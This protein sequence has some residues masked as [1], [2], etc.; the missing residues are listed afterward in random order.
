MSNLALVK[1]APFG[2]V[3]CDFWQNEQHD[4]FMTIN[5][6]AQALG[7]ASKSGVEKIVQRNEYL[8]DIEFSATDILSAPDGKR[9]ETRIFTEDGIYEVSMLAKTPVAKDF[10]QWVRKILKSL[11]KGDY[12]LTPTVTPKLTVT[13]TDDDRKLEIEARLRNSKTR[14]ARLLVSVAEKFKDIL[15]K[16]QIQILIG[17]ATELISDAPMLPKPEIPKTYTA[18]QIGAIVGV[19]GNKVGRI[20]NKHGL[21]TDEYGIWVLDKSRHSDKQVSSFQYNEKGKRK[22]IELLQQEGQ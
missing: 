10:R 21:K 4:I 5:Q 1:S 19:S 8:K 18:G 13:E 20:A 12:Q 6:L 15:P 17:N 2:T 9:Y 3:Q 16:E 11:R 7:Y 22:I 14:Q